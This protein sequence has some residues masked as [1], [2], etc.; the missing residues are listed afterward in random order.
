MFGFLWSW[1]YQ[2]FY[3]TIEEDVE[4]DDVLPL[5]PTGIFE[6]CSEAR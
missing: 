1:L 2:Y 5:T 4:T 3:S 6:L